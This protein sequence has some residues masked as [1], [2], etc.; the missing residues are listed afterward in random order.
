VLVSRLEARVM[1]ERVAAAVMA[2][3]GCEVELPDPDEARA[4][5]DEALAAEPSQVDVEKELLLRGLGLR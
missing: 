3:A 2:A 5:F 4:R 1:N